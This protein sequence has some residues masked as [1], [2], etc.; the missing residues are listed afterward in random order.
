MSLLHVYIVIMSEV[1]LLVAV[2]QGESVKALNCV[3]SHTYDHSE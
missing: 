3:G 2:H 1:R